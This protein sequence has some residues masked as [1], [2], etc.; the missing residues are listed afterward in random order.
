M[1][2]AELEA[3]QN[4]RL[5]SLYEEYGDDAYYRINHLPDKSYPSMPEGIEWIFEVI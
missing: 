1:Q 3:E 2:Y 5:S 4:A